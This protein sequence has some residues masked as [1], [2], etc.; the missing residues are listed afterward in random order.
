MVPTFGDG[1]K[2]FSL[3]PRLEWGHGLV[4]RRRVLGEEDL[5]L[6]VFFIG[7]GI[8]ECIVRRG[9]RASIPQKAALEPPA[10]TFFHFQRLSEER[11]RAYQ[12]EASRIF[13]RALAHAL[14]SLEM[15]HAISMI[16]PRAWWDSALFRCLF[17][18]LKALDMGQSLHKTR[19]VFRW[20]VL[21]ATGHSPLLLLPMGVLKDRDLFKDEKVLAVV[22]G[23]W[24][25]V[26]NLPSL[27][28]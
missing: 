26:F 20:T 4:L 17:G 18:G 9:A 1:L 13:R 21:E 25:S 10:L 28:E 23:L 12:W 27:M 3:P 22:E 19:L 2:S 6:E 16:L 24:K 15:C 8:Q 14:L 7:K 5:S 11:V